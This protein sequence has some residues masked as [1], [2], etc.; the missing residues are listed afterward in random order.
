MKICIILGERH[1]SSEHE[2]VHEKVNPNEWLHESQC[3]V[4][5]NI[6]HETRS[7]NERQ[8]ILCAKKVT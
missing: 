4:H 7:L 2:V 6:V 3:S 8:V 5:M 1:F